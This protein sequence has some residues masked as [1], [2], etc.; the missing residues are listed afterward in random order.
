MNDK[1]GNDSK[2]KIVIDHDDLL[3]TSEVGRLDVSFN[4]FETSNVDKG[5]YER[6]QASKVK[7]C[8]N[9]GGRLLGG[10][11]NCSKCGN[12]VQK[13]PFSRIPG[14]YRNAGQ[15]SEKAMP[16]LESFLSGNNARFIVH[17]I[18]V[19]AL[20]CM[21]LPFIS[22]AGLVT[23]SGINLVFGIDLGFGA[24]I[25]NHWAGALILLT[26]LGGIGLFFW[27]NHLKN[28][29][30]VVLSAFGVFLLIGIAVGISTTLSDITGDFI[31][32]RSYINY[33]IGFYLL[34]L[35]FLLSGVV[36]VFNVRF[37]NN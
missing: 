14:A 15:Y 33:G 31:D 24:R 10:G 17:G 6:D 2:D 18:Y 7:Y 16:Y 28:K 29:V 20:F 8:T 21:F 27:N 5:K 9:C 22:A 19:F 35:S 12:S 36:S 23:L 11:T 26:I 32:I 34:F 1:D 4:D 13:D 25:G 30:L 3:D 37:E